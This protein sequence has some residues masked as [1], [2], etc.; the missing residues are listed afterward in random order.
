LREKALHNIAFSTALPTN[1]QFPSSLNMETTEPYRVL[2]RCSA[3]PDKTCAI[4][5]FL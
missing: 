2:V 3:Y 5:H 1:W 4:G